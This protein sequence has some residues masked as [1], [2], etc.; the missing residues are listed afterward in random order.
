M[1]LD[2]PKSTPLALSRGTR[3]LAERSARNT[4]WLPLIRT[5]L[6]YCKKKNLP[7]TA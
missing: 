6:I 7:P 1:H 4:Q 5:G 3:R 2:P